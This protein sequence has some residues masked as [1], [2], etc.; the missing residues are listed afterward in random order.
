MAVEERFFL[1]DGSDQEFDYYRRP[2]IVKGPSGVL[3]VYYEGQCFRYPCYQKLFCRVSRNDGRTWSDRIE[4]ANGGQTGMLHNIMMV[5]GKEKLHCLWNVQYRQLWHCTS[6]D[7]ISWSQPEDLTRAI[8]RA[9]TEY[10]WN[11]FGIG[12]GHGITLRS[13][14]ILLPTWFTTGGDS[15]KPSAFANLYTDDEFQTIQIGK[16]LKED[17]AH[18]TIINPNE[19]AVVELMDGRVMATVRHDCNKRQRAV[20]YSFGGTEEWSLPQFRPDLPDP[21]CHASLERAEGEIFFCNCA[22]ADEGVEEKIKNGQCKYNWSNDARKNLMLRVSRDEGEHFSKGILLEEKGGY[23]DL[24]VLEN[25]IIC[26][27][28][29]GWREEPE[30]C[31]FPRQIG[32]SIVG[33]DRL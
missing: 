9:D 22:N 7:G 24:A 3:V 1:E 16:V 2:G 10:P 26:V 12:S 21:I 23:S 31:I 25:E 18:S 27:Y 33:R 30:T 11:A 13:G 4:L 19:G 32:V 8:W 29:T 28:E 20:S 6:A 5:M 15:H 14:R 17:A